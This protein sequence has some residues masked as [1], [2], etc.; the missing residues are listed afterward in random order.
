LS[1]LLLC[2]LLS[3]SNFA[4]YGLARRN[5]Y[6]KD[7]HEWIYTIAHPV[8]VCNLG[9][10]HPIHP[11]IFVGLFVRL[12]LLLFLFLLFLWLLLLFLFGLY[13]LFGL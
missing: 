6:I 9:G 2:L 1:I 3:R 5:S 8:F 11:L 12:S 7:V 10:F 4:F 13:L